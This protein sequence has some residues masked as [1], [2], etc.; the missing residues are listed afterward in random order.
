MT[1]GAG[2]A[3][4]TAIKTLC[5]PG[6]EVLVSAPLFM[7]YRFYASNHGAQLK[8]VSSLPG[9][10]LDLDAIE[11][12]ISEKTAVFLINSP[13]NPS[14][15]VYSE[16]QLNALG[17]LLEKKSR[18]IGRR[19]YLV[20]DEPYRRI[21]YNGIT[22]PS[23]FKAY[24][25]S[26][27]ATSFSKELSIPGE[28]IG[29]LAVHPRAEDAANIYNGAVLCN[30]ILGYVNAPGIMQKAV[31]GAL[32][33]VVDMSEYTRNREILCRGLQDIGYSLYEP[34]GTFYLFPEAPGGEDG[35][36]KL[37]DALRNHRVLV[38]PGSGFGAPGFF[39][40]SFCV[41]SD[42]VQRSLPF[43]EAAFKEVTA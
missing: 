20:S 2:G 32:D 26:L 14:G 12:A 24:S 5:N 1:V 10:D 13:N 35:E 9:F 34:D 3:L 23:V 16:K 37:V 30:R 8:I 40:I 6:D 29:W 43:F 4:N 11:E 25:H 22:V 38:V 17:E 19:I 15:K 28:R 7:E 41:D 42:T 18:E 21:V 36:Q 39:R 33:A 31:A 27:V